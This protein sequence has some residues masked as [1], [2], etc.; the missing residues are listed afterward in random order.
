MYLLDTDH[1]TL[2]DRGGREGQNIRDR[3]A[4][5][6]ADEVAASIV[7][8]EEQMRGWM[9][10]INRLRGMDRQADGY[11]RLERLLEF[12]CETPLLPFDEGAVE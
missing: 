11:R 3:L 2:I 1:I 5:I 9:A 12:Y 8:Y 10:L 4:L 7:I 6:P